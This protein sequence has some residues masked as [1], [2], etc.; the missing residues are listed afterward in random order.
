MDIYYNSSG[1]NCTSHSF[2]IIERETEKTTWYRAIGK[3]ESEQ[4]CWWQTIVSPNPEVRTDHIFSIRKS[5]YGHPRLYEGRILMDSTGAQFDNPDVDFEWFDE[6]GT[7][8]K[9]PK[10][11]RTQGKW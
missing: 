4:D 5:S 10:D 8:T 11:W 2:W 9:R 6:N 7:V 3:H 1:Y